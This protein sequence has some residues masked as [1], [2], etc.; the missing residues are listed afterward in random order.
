MSVPSP[1]A[2]ARLS[3]L[4]LIS[5]GGPERPAGRRAHAGGGR[6]GR[7]SLPAEALAVIAT[8]LARTTPNAGHA[9]TEGTGRRYARLLETALYDTWLI[10]WSPS[11]RLELHDH[12]GS[13]GVVSVVSGRLVE[14]STDL[15]Q[16]GP[17]HARVVL[18][19]D[20]ITIAATGVHGMSNPGPADAL[21]VHVYSPPLRAMTFFDHR[22][23]SFLHPLS[24]IT[25][26]RAVLEEAA[27]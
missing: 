1:L 21:S 27:T 24:T 7:R 20:T 6:R 18:A 8:G 26:D 13:V 12:G 23:V 17:L 11:S 25:G 9:W 3:D 16:P 19:G 4:S 14:T 5:G 22:P 10:A 2:G 15:R